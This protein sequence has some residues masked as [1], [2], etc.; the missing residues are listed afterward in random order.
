M[1]QTALLQIITAMFSAVMIV[2]AGLTILAYYQQ[3]QIGAER[4]EKKFTMLVSLGII[5]ISASEI[6]PALFPQAG[7]FVQAA[8]FIKI[9]AYVL[10]SLALYS[11]FKKYAGRY[12]D[13][14]AQAAPQTQSNAGK[15]PKT[16]AKENR[17]Q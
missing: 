11:H 4:R 1:A 16:P 14:T 15:T 5:A 12:T 3:V 13:P 9:I 10:F 17:K 2:F 7:E 6:L 8:L